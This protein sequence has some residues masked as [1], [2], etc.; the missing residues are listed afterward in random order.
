[1]RL[2]GLF[3]CSM[4][5]VAVY[6]D[7]TLTK[8][9]DSSKA[10]SKVS[11]QVVSIKQSVLDL[12][13]ELYQLEKELLNPATTRAAVYLSLSGGEFFELHSVTIAIDDQNPIQYLYTERQLAALRQGAVHPVANLNIGPGL[14]SFNVVVKGKNHQG[15]AAE[16]AL[17]KQIE[18]NRQPLYL[19]LIH[20]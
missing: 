13:R 19:S 4:L 11:D 17:E 9:S 16:M 2:I 14:H 8:E 12:N 3:L 15:L 6:G 5:S 18:K 20:I 7:S 1:M 10:S